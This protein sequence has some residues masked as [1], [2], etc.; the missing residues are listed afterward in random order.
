VLLSDKLA[1]LLD[2]SEFRAMAT[3]SKE[4]FESIS[5]SKKWRSSGELEKVDQE[6]LDT[7]VPW[8]KHPKFVNLMLKNDGLSTIARML[9]RDENN[10]PTFPS[11]EVTHT[12]LALTNN[13]IL[14]VKGKD[15]VTGYDAENPDTEQF[16]RD[17]LT[18]LE[19]T[20]LLAQALR[21]LTAPMDPERI[22]YEH[23]LQI[24]KF[25][26]SHPKI[27]RKKLKSG[28][29]SGDILNGLLDGSDGWTGAAHKATPE[30]AQVMKRLRALK[31]FAEMSNEAHG[32]GGSNVL[33]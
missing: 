28:T 8:L 18:K 23:A 29:P 17:P 4:R 12:I 15:E 21:F 10:K 3:Y 32:P 2:D 14:T 6:L 24:V 33:G 13:T 26:E 22:Q 11:L 25:I 27:M 1:K 30:Y 19:K 31:D 9:A 7:L 16:G 5:S 20:G